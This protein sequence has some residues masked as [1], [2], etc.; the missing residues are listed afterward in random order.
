MSTDLTTNRI[1]SDFID[2]PLIDPKPEACRLAC[3]N[4]P[5]CRAYTYTAPSNPGMSAR[6]QLK[7]AQ[8][9]AASDTCCV[10]GVKDSIPLTAE[11]MPACRAFTSPAIGSTG[12][13]AS[14]YPELLSTNEVIKQ[15]AEL[16]VADPMKQ[17]FNFAYFM[18]ARAP[19]YWQILIEDSKQP[20]LGITFP[21]LSSDETYVSLLNQAG[22]GEAAV[23][24]IDSASCSISQQ[25]TVPEGAARTIRVTRGSA[26]TIVL[27]RKICSWLCLSRY[28]QDIGIWSEPAFWPTFGARWISFT[29]YNY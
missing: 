26:T 6:C 23:T 18:K 12:G 4:D 27:S 13:S 20:V 14:P 28:W 10:S 11:T 3:A 16:R 25:I 5:M 21:T 19:D 1:G 7:S 24:A 9:P 29:W 8:P 22:N 2:F 17:T 15:M